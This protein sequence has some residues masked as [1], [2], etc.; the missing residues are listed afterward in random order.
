SGSAIHV[1]SLLALSTAKFSSLMKR[2]GLHVTDRGSPM[3][4][5][6]RRGHTGVVATRRRSTY[7]AERFWPGSREI[8]PPGQ[9]ET[10]CGH[11]SV[12]LHET[13]TLVPAVVGRRRVRWKEGQ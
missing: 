10:P 7:T 8:V 5:A 4:S 3:R 13:H 11:V 9:G 2:F 6:A 12:V 1:T